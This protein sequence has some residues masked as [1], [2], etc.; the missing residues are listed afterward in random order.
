MAHAG[1]AP[2]PEH[3]PEQPKEVVLSAES[4]L[5]PLN[6]P[7]ARVHQG[8]PQ[9]PWVEGDARTGA[10]QP[11]A[12]PG[13]PAP[14]SVWAAGPEA[15][16]VDR[17]ALEA[18]H[19]EHVQQVQR[20]A[21]H[22]FYVQHRH[23]A[24]FRTMY[25]PVAALE[26][27]EERAAAAA[28]AAAAL[29]ARAVAEGTALL[30]QHVHLHPQ[31]VHS[32]AGH[33]AVTRGASWW[34]DRSRVLLVRNVPSFVQGGDI[35]SAL[36]ALTA[37][38]REKTQETLSFAQSSAE[39]GNDAV[40]AAAAVAQAALD[41]AQPPVAVYCANP[42]RGMDRGD[43][44]HTYNARVEFPTAAAAAAAL[45]ELP[46]SGDLVV[47]LLEHAS[48]DLQA[49]RAAQAARA[50][51]ILKNATEHVA[52]EH[53]MAP[54][55][56][57]RSAG[58]G[59]VDSSGR[60]TR[61]GRAA[62]SGDNRSY[63]AEVDR[64]LRFL[65]LMA[66]EAA[67]S[68]K[69]DSLLSI[70]A[71]LP[72]AS[73]DL[74]SA[75]QTAAMEQWGMEANAAEQVAAEKVK[76]GW[77]SLPDVPAPPAAVS[78]VTVRVRPCG[79][80]SDRPLPPKVSEPAV[81]Q[82]DLAAAIKLAR[83]LDV[84]N[85][86]SAPGGAG[87]AAAAAAMGAAGA[88]VEGEDA[89]GSDS[90]DDG[91]VA[92]SSSAV[93]AVSDSAAFE[94]VT[95]NAWLCEGAGAVD[96]YM[97][98]F[99]AC[100][101]V[102]RLDAVLTYLAWVHLY[103]WYS[104]LQGTSRGDW[105]HIATDS[106][107]GRV[108]PDDSLA[109]AA[110]HTVTAAAGSNAA[111]VPDTEDANAEE[112][113]EDATKDVADDEDEESATPAVQADGA[114]EVADAIAVETDGAEAEGAVPP[115]AAQ[116]PAKTTVAAARPVLHE[117]VTEATMPSSACGAV[118]ALK[119]APGRKSMLVTE[120]CLLAVLVRL[121][122]ARRRVATRCGMSLTAVLTT[123]RKAV[124]MGELSQRSAGA[125][126]ASLRLAALVFPALPPKL[127]RDVNF[128][129]KVRGLAALQPAAQ[130]LSSAVHTQLA[131]LQQSEL[132]APYY[133][134][135]LQA[136]GAPNEKGEVLTRCL[137]GPKKLF[138]DRPFA[139][140]HLHKKQAESVEEGVAQCTAQLSRAIHARC[141]DV[142]MWVAFA[143]DTGRPAA[144]LTA[145]GGSSQTLDA[146]MAQHADGGARQGRGARPAG[147]RAHSGGSRGPPRRQF[148]GAT[149]GRHNGPRQAGPRHGYIDADAVP[150]RPSIGGVSGVMRKSLSA[151][152][153]YGG[154]HVSYDDI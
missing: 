67:T 113:D 96:E 80:Q 70:S 130:A 86:L 60:P 103:D 75:I 38:A 35:M 23:H 95:S 126:A 22:N 141:A 131:S 54:I 4:L 142:H 1:H 112:D 93:P 104:G 36:T 138:R 12:P 154:A 72:V 15:A 25:D 29:T 9:V 110:T 45:A 11:P 153:A 99:D 94:M 136:E 106:L 39:G 128:S 66:R 101:D 26:A 65:Q 152:P 17:N 98:H 91:A 73:A 58:N 124:S 27:T 121:R 81:V 84:E 10:G 46:A 132:L 127:A 69:A 14:F 30:P 115:A 71:H 149:G 55:V 31:D 111:I 135:V 146:K 119:I 3:V 41:A 107:Q 8:E 148:G 52:V 5:P 79:P 61:A 116:L 37:A 143:A 57:R 32:S 59:L 134:R 125:A 62:W 140:K 53:D 48:A 16:G 40:S 49:L 18:A 139:L 43:L 76:G 133:A 89:A 117:V 34:G 20:Q 150:S 102:Q 33:S 100:S 74:S 88:E 92:E 6:P 47:P 19:A 82:R 13:Y 109:R 50:E 144:H 51:S 151:R 118:C 105:L 78:S 147:P 68:A 85:S 122:T 56:E 64:E 63:D 83:A 44:C 108:V 42:A 114:A 7:L 2:V 145:S 21:A 97:G 77:H 120:R 90:D 28:A 137:L 123:E 129:Q 87:G 24:W